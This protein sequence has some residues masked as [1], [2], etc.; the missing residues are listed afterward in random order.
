[1]PLKIYE[2][3][4]ETRRVA[5][6]P[7]NYL[8]GGSCN[9]E[10]TAM[11]L[12]EFQMTCLGLRGNA[13]TQIVRN[14][15]GSV[16]ELNPLNAR[17]MHIDRNAAGKLVF[18]YQETGNA[19][20][21]SERDIWRIAGL[22]TNGVTG[23]SP[24]ALAKESIGVSLA[25]ES[26]AARIFSNGANTNTV[27]EFPGKLSPEQITNLRD[28][29]DQ[30]QTGHRNSG[31]PWILESGMTHKSVGMTNDDSQFLESRKFQIAEIARWYRVP[32]HMLAEMS[33]ATFG[34]IEHQSIEFVVHTIRP[35]LV[36]IEQSIARDLLTPVERQR[37][38]ASHTVEGLLRGDTATRYEA[39]G[40]G[41]QDGWMN[42][43]EVR[44]LENM[45]PA[46]GLDEYVLPMNI[47]TIS[48]REKA[49][50]TTGANMLAEREIKAL[51]VE[52][53]RLSAPEFAAWLPGFYQRHAATIAD[54]LAIDPTK[55]KA[56]TDERIAAICE[57]TEP[58][59]AA[60]VTSASLAIKI[61]A[62]T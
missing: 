51:K 48:E 56:Y 43:N 12:R 21:Y 49:L 45:N 22:G 39:Y 10:Q 26:H 18:D 37:L 19:G 4:G 27:L 15:A 41:I 44:K 9:G 25:T 30:N 13:F 33:A 16:A 7:L 2:T 55:A 62:L 46:D 1:L 31:K 34:N 28:Q 58:T 60:Q 53:E 17:Y 42:R 50:T 47:S 8:L 5:N 61:E 40:K 57:L 23:Q 35:W 6:H 54:T 29:L 3:Q 32:L 24:I 38:Y 11:E 36:R 52:A 59:Q 14:G 20:V